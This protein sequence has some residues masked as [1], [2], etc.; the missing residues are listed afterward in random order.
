MTVVNAGELLLDGA[1]EFFAAALF[2]EGASLFF[3]R[4]I[5]E[6]DPRSGLAEQADGRGSDAA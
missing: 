2:D 3:G 5:A 4:A 6:D 1:A